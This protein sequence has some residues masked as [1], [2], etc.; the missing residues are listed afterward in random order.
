M[1]A[2]GAHRHWFG[3]PVLEALLDMVLLHP[4]PSSITAQTVQPSVTYTNAFSLLFHG[5]ACS[6]SATCVFTAAQHVLGIRRTS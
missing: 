3:W 4:V 1:Q 2:A 5:R 6:C